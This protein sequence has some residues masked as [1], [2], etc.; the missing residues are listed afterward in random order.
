MAAVQ[1]NALKTGSRT[2][3][4]HHEKKL[5]V[6]D[7][8]I[9]VDIRLGDDFSDL[10]EAHLRAEGIATS[11]TEPASLHNTLAQRT[12]TSA[13]FDPLPLAHSVRLCAHLPHP[14]LQKLHRHLLLRDEAVSIAVQLGKSVEEILFARR[15]ARVHGGRQELLVVDPAPAIALLHA[16][17]LKQTLHLS[18]REMRSP[19]VALKASH[20][21]IEGDHARA[22][23]IHVEE[24]PPEA[25]DLLLLQVPDEELRACGE[26]EE[27]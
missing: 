3:R 1:M 6:V 18:W 8:S 9:V 22:V 15:L 2:G 21:L 26:G 24:D 23:R 4:R 5:S 20:E 27:R 14:Q 7:H 12:R 25:L 10:V 17:G 13:S 16:H 11:S 19:P